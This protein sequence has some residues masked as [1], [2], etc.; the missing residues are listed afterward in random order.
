[1]GRDHIG[2][3]DAALRRRLTAATAVAIALAAGAPLL[4]GAEPT[5]SPAAAPTPASAQ[6][7]R[8]GMSTSFTGP[9]RSLG[10][11]VYRGARAH[12]D[13]L[14]AAGGVGGR[15]IVLDAMDDRYDPEQAL[16]N[17]LKF[18]SGDRYLALFGYVGTATVARSL[19]L[20]RLRASERMLLFFSLSGGDPQR[21][22]PYRDYAWNLRASYNQEALALVEKFLAA[23]RRRVGV[24]FQMGSF[25]RSGWHGVQ[26]ALRPAGLRI[27]GEATYPLAAPFTADYRPQVE[28]L[29]AA[30]PDVVIA[31]GLHDAV[32]GFVRDA[33][34]AGW[35]VPIAALSGASAE[36]LTEQ[37]L[38]AGTESG[39]DYTSRLV[40]SQVVPSYEDL[41]LP[42]V[43]EYRAAMERFAPPLEP[44]P[45]TADYR[46]QPYSYASFE[47]YLDAK[48]FA[49]I[50]RR[51]APVTRERLA[52]AAQSLTGYDLGIGTPMDFSGGRRQA[53]DTVYFTH[54]VAGRSLPLEDWTPF[55]LAAEN[56]P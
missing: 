40:M 25:G 53:I 30:Q 21:E 7:L 43:R 1:M 31:V 38:R 9:N 55:S 23:G 10:I 49:E 3:N 15:Q 54:V 33:R 11:E 22:P 5:L 51:A 2:F 36:H 34:D 35:Q 41:G 18:L 28:L 8:L 6:E 45:A 20:L 12:F 13:Q 56:R 16:D 48:L 42:A 27:V 32:A 14:N 37:L 17:T 29:R 52:D 19:P 46:P 4:R 50:L 44:A 47:G 24:F 26:I 39:A